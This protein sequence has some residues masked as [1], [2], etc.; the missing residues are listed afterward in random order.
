MNRTAVGLGAVD[1]RTVVLEVRAFKGVGLEF[2]AT[3]LLTS[4]NHL[5]L[6]PP[7]LTRS[8]PW[9]W[10]LGRVEEYEDW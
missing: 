3:L 6:A 5:G 8:A 10:G 4:V 1:L 7:L 2:W 9:A